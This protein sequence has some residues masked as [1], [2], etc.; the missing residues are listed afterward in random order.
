VDCSQICVS[1]IAKNTDKLVLKK[2]PED[3]NTNDYILLKELFTDAM[4]WVQENIEK[5][6]IHLSKVIDYHNTLAKYLVPTT[7]VKEGSLNLEQIIQVF[8]RINLGGKKLNLYSIVS[9]YNYVPGKFDLD[10]HFAELNANKLINYGE[11]SDTTFLQTISACLIHK[12]NKP[13]ILEG[14][15]QENKKVELRSQYAKIEQALLRAV[16]HLKGNNYGVRIRANLPYEALLVTFTY[17]YYKLKSNYP[18]EIQTKLLCDY[19][20]RAILTNSYVTA[21]DSTLNADLEKIDCIL[22]NEQPEYEPFAFTHSN[23]IANGKSKSS[24]FSKG[25]ICLMCTKTPKSFACGQEV[26]IDNTANSSSSKKQDHHF[27]PKKSKAITQNKEYKNKVNNVV[28]IV[29]IDALTNDAINN[30]N[31]S[32]YI[33]EFK[34]KTEDFDK[35]LRSHFIE[36]EGYGL[37]EDDF[38]LFLEARSKAIFKELV[39]KLVLTKN[40]KI[41]EL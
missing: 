37:E 34:S 15:T 10:K 9:A 31:P 36:L 30:K 41:E 11:I 7:K 32:Q 16:D 38:D 1:L 24:A 13:A 4:P 6:T 14:L 21:T 22:N 26:I 28:N 39:D 27:F 2:M 23:V 8:E 5:R 18:T 19:F 35:V 25:I 29:L 33:P 3:G 12:C 17:F 40:D 20:W